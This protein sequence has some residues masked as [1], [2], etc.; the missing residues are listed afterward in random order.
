MLIIPA[1]DILE[2][3]LVRLTQGD[4]QQI[5]DY[6]LSPLETFRKYAEAGAQRIHLIFLGAAREGMRDLEEDPILLEILKEKKRFGVQVEVGGGIR[7]MDE[8]RRLLGWGVDYVILGTAVILDAIKINEQRLKI[9]YPK[10]LGDFIA[11]VDPPYSSLIRE[12]ILA[13]IMEKVIIGLDCKKGAVAISGW[14]VTLPPRPEGLARDF[15]EMGFHQIILTSIEQDG[16]LLGPDIEGIKRL[17]QAAPE[18]SLIAAGGIGGEEDITKLIQLNMPNLK[19][20]IVGKA[21]YEGKID[22]QKVIRQY[23]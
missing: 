7:T 9:N 12:I 6:G 2:K 10:S 13:G 5:T 18:I 4:Y 11:E 16:T 17:A 19:G 21:L 3:R 20:I 23:Q 1:I 15:Q 14:E 22:L 8:V